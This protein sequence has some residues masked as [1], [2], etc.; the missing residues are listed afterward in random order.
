MSAAGMLFGSHSRSHRSLAALSDEEAEE[1]IKGSKKSLE[2]LLRTPV[3]WFA[4]PFGLWDD[5][6]PEHANLVQEAGYRA[7]LTAKA[8]ANSLKSDFYDLRVIPVYEWDS[9]AEFKKKVD[10]G[11]DWVGFF[12]HLWIEAFPKNRNAIKGDTKWRHE[13]GRSEASS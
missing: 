9:I 8:G 7:A 6:K 5:I 12:H 10:G 2:S 4:F 11:Y 1:E 13:A 3:E